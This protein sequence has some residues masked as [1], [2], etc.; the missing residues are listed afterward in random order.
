MPPLLQ[1]GV[2]T[3]SPN[4]RR[5]EWNIHRLYAKRM[6]ATR[7]SGWRKNLDKFHDHRR[8]RLDPLNRADADAELSG[9]RNCLGSSAASTK[10]SAMPGKAAVY[11]FASYHEI[12][13]S[14]PRALT[15]S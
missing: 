14:R 12:S 3:D 9:V 10:R 4:F 1:G 15:P 6:H 7:S 8:C 5:Y 2:S 13:T 11:R